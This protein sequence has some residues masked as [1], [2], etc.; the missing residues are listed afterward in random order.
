MV[1]HRE[2]Y[3]YPISYESNPAS[4][5]PQARIVRYHGVPDWLGQRKVVGEKTLVA[6]D[7]VTQTTKDEANVYAVT[8][9]WEWLN[10]NGPI[11]GEPQE[12]PRCGLVSPPEAQR[13]DCGYDFKTVR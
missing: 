4:W 10:R 11:V 7:G 5:I 9:G 12:C 13:C 1:D 3:V 6:P 8:M 2:P